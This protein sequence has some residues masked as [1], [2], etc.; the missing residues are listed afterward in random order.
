MQTPTSKTNVALLTGSILSVATWLLGQF[1]I[2]IPPEVAAAVVTLVSFGASY[3]K[4][5]N[6][7]AG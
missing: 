7:P 5:E 1:H 3:V 6:N 4:S 2:V